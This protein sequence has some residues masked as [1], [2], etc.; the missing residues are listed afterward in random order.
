LKF[1][2]TPSQ[3]QVWTEK[4]EREGERGM[5]EDRERVELREVHRKKRRKL[6]HTQNY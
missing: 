5:N 6:T 1:C 4:G 3:S 2:E